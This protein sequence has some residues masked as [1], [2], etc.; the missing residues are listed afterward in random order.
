MVGV[1][2]GL[3]HYTGEGVAFL[4]IF[5]CTPT[6]LQGAF[7]GD[8]QLNFII[9]SSS[10]GYTYHPAPICFP[11][12]RSIDNKNEI[13]GGGFKAMTWHRRWQTGESPFAALESKH[14][15]VQSRTKT[16]FTS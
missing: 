16:F 8:T 2:S 15:Q 1:D 13:D 3:Y 4:S 11:V 5:L 7:S 12:S 10:F 6:W 14:G 9:H